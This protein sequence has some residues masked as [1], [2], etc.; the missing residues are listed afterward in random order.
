MIDPM[1]NAVAKVIGVRRPAWSFI[2]E[3]SLV[4]IMTK[5]FIVDWE[6]IDEIIDSGDFKIQDVVTHR[7]LGVVISIRS[8]A[9]K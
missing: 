2:I 9:G 4:R 3:D 5:Q 6:I 7:E 8:L 1:F